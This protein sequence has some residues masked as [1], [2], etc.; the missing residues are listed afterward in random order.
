MSRKRRTNSTTGLAENFAPL[1]V[2]NIRKGGYTHVI[3]GHTTFWEELDAPGVAALLD[4][5]Q[6]SDV[7]AIEGREYIRGDPSY[8]RQRDCH[9]GVFRPREDNH[10]QGAQLFR[11]PR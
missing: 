7:T 4:S 5:Q 8:C 9:R 1:L 6:V 11:R 2:E 3:A 10:G